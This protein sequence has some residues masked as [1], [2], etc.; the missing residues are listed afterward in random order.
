MSRSELDALDAGEIV[1]RPLAFERHGGRYVGGLAYQV[2]RA[3]A[4]QVWAA[5]TDV[6]SLPQA[7]PRT[8]SAKIVA[9][10]DDHAHVELVQGNNLVD[11]TYTVRLERQ[12]P[13]ELRFWLDHRRPHDIDDV[14]GYFRV[15]S[16]GRGRCLV[17]VAVALDMG[18]GLA[19]M[20]FERRIQEL[21]LATPRHIKQFVEPRALAAR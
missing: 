5:L 10:H 1:T 13:D 17:T 14:W 21:V 3:E 11:A 7:L 2:V 16:L 20:L 18:P 9:T 19:R 6:A 8:K 4:D 12:T 15:Q